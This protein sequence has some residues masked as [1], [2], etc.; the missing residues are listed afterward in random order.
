MSPECS[1]LPNT[2]G[3][4]KSMRLIFSLS[5]QSYQQAIFFPGE[6]KSCIDLFLFGKFFFRKKISEIK[7]LKL[8]HIL[9]LC[10]LCQVVSKMVALVYVSTS[11]AGGSLDHPILESTG[12]PL[13]V[14]CL[15]LV[16]SRGETCYFVDLMSISLIIRENEYVFLLFVN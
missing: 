13:L 2:M 8:S 16:N 9:R 5:A 4:S 10:V 1:Y 15:N 12:H 3:I 7:L 14:F 6:K 11:D